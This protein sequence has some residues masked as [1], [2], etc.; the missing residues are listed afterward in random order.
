MKLPALLSLITC[1]CLMADPA[2]NPPSSTPTGYTKP[3]GFTLA[4]RPWDVHITT[5][6]TYWEAIQDN[7]ELGII[8]VPAAPPLLMNGSFI[9]DNVE[10]KPGFQVELGFNTNY[11]GWD[12]ALTYTW[13]KSTHNTSASIDTSSSDVI[14]ASWLSPITSISFQSASESWKLQMNIVDWVLG[15]SSSFGQKLLLRPFLGM[16][17]ALIDQ[18]ASAEYYNVAAA[19]TSFYKGKSESW[20]LGPEV[21][22]KA[23]WKLGAGFRLYSDVE[24]DILYTRYTSLDLQEGRTLAGVTSIRRQVDQHNLSSLRPHCDLEL[25]FKWGT[26]FADHTAHIDLAL[27]YGF[28]IFWSQ[29]MFR[30]FVDDTATASSFSPNGDLYLQGLTA[31]V[32]FDF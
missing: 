32:R 7:M 29:N 19:Q 20:A 13:Y 25:G 22:I 5:N 10:Y 21:G 14:Y 18:H 17:A 6:F 31:S 12:T 26:Y 27:G 28:Q 24:A 30:K 2:P 9:N 16:R 11:D 23:E 15:R 1:S 8:S 3:S 4:D